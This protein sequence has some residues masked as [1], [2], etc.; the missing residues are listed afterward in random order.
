VRRYGVHCIRREGTLHLTSEWGE[1]DSI[2]EVVS[3][4]RKEM[5][6]DQRRA[7]KVNNLRY[8]HVIPTW[9]AWSGTTCGC[10][11]FLTAD[12]VVCLADRCLARLQSC[13]WHDI[14]PTAQRIAVQFKENS[15]K[16]FALREYIIIL[17]NSSGVLLWRWGDRVTGGIRRILTSIVFIFTVG[18]L[19][20]CKMISPVLGIFND[21]NKIFYIYLQI[22]TL[23][24]YLFIYDQV[25]P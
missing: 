15:N 23:R 14:A 8:Y 9:S 16:V 5:L 18:I 1:G 19:Y 2:A 6:R 13:R 25:Q 4:M 10:R 20:K 21:E 11:D 17:A 3:F 7:A 22:S 12:I 24:W